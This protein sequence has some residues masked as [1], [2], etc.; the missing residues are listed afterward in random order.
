VTGL[1]SGAIAYMVSEQLA[2]DLSPPPQNFPTESEQWDGACFTAKTIWWCDIWILIL[3]MPLYCIC[4]NGKACDGCSWAGIWKPEKFIKR[5]EE[6]AVIDPDEDDTRTR[7]Q[8]WKDEFLAFTSAF[9]DPC[10][11]WLWIQG[12]VGQ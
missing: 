5:Q 6:V 12:F 11:R 1:G 3:Q 7:C 10:Y 9:R 4:C 2:C 8:R